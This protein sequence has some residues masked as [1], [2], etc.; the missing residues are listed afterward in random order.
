MQMSSTEN[1]QAWKNSTQAK[2]YYAAYREANREK[3]RAYAKAYYR[4]NWA[5]CKEWREGRK[6]IVA[7]YDKA[8]YQAAPEL[9]KARSNKW[10]SENKDK[11]NSRE[12]A[13]RAKKKQR[14][15][16]W[17]TEE[18]FELIESFYTEAQRRI[19][20]T[21]VKYEVDHIVPLLGKN[22]SGLHVPWNL[23]VLTEKE[24]RTKRN[25]F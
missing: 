19:Q 6:D 10:K 20:A 3:A 1:Q 23:Q 14:T 7:E 17:L 24:N 5:K 12:S 15:P 8:R 9:H 13:K 2:E 4:A 21:D 18:D 22:V 25:K 11:V 16:N